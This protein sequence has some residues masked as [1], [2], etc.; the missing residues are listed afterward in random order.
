M[1]KIKNNISKIF[2]L[3]IILIF[4]WIVQNSILN[5]D[6][7]IYPFNPIWLILGLIIYIPALIC[8]N[9]YLVPKLSKIKFLHFI[10]FFLFFIISVII[11][12]F[13]RVNPTWDMGQTFNIAKSYTLTNTMEGS[14]YLISYPNN[15]MITGLYTI[16]FKFVYLFKIT[17]FIT[18]ATMFNACIITGT[19]ICTYYIAKNIYNKEKAL[20]TLIILLCTTP[21]Y[22]HV[23]IYYTDSMSMFFSTV[24]L[25]LFILANKQTNKVKSIILQIIIGI[26]IV[27]AWKVKITSIFVAIAIGV[28]YILKKYDKENIKRIIL[29]IPITIVVFLAYN[30]T[31]ENRINHRIDRDQ[32]Q[33]PVEHWIL[34][35]LTGNGGFSQEIYEY[36]SSYPTYSEKKE[37]DIIKIKEVINQYTCNDFI[38]HLTVKLKF[39]WSDGTYF[40]PEK[41]RREPVDKNILHKFILADGEYNKYYKYFPQVMHIGLLILII[42]STIKM[43]K[44]KD[45]DSK[46]MILVIAISGL[47]LFLLL[48]ENRSRYILTMLP[49]YILL[50]VDGIDYIEKYIRKKKEAN[51]NEK[52]I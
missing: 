36:T 25:L 35:G 23:A 19:V 13:M 2:L 26:F 27:I 38:K 41:L 32:Y 5:Y 10:L 43:L 11:G 3:F 31:I 48:W 45:Y 46:K 30:F 9:K 52:N 15:I 28:Y 22:L 7:I 12:Y 50:G 40:A 34:L 4:I 51:T 47:I 44:E 37:A 39:A 49:I 17:D 42:F 33:M 16:L 8:I 18:V 1:K 14:T 20:M 6:T 29:V 24:I 21:L